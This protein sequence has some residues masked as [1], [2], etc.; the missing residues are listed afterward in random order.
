MTKK[1]KSSRK[2][3]KIRRKKT[4]KRKIKGGS[5]I[6]NQD[7]F[8]DSRDASRQASFFETLVDLNN[9]SSTSSTIVSIKKKCQQDL[10]KCR[11][12]KEQ[13][14]NE[15]KQDLKKC[16]EENKELLDKYNKTTQYFLNLQ[17]LM[18]N[19]DTPTENKNHIIYPDSNKTK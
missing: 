11:E 8:S 18:K 7:E 10:Q 14:K 4:I 1:P 19:K 5:G 16:Q 12:E 3:I 2:K 9:A 6:R 13:L 15:S 17:E